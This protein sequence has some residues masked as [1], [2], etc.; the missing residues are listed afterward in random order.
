MRTPEEQH[1]PKGSRERLSTSAASFCIVGGYARMEREGRPI[2]RQGGGD[3]CG[4]CCRCWTKPQ[5]ACSFQVNP[6]LAALRPLPKKV[7]VPDHPG[8]AVRQHLDIEA[9]AEGGNLPQDQPVQPSG[10]RGTKVNWRCPAGRMPSIPSVTIRQNRAL[11]PLR[12]RL[13]PSGQASMA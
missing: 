5:A 7:A 13:P 10:S 9:G 11:S 2:R 6:H 1:T 3:L 4:F 8:G 12:C